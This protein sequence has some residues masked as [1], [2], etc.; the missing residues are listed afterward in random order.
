MTHEKFL[1]AGV[2]RNNKG[3]L[4]ARYSTLTVAETIARQERAGQT[5]ILYVDLPEPM[6]REDIP[7]YL[8]TLE[9]FTSVPDFK[10]CL[11]DANTNHVLKSKAPRAKTVWATPA[12]KT[13]KV[14]TPKPVK[15][16]KVRLPKPD[17]EDDLMIEELKALVAA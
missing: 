11:E 7:A 8:L 2:A 9:A 15:A 6:S 12:P 16:P 5:D 1:V 17:A 3:Q 13:A 4:R 10:A 14:N